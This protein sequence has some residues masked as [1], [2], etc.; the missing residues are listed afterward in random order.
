[1]NPSELDTART[2]ALRG[3]AVAY[4]GQDSFGRYLFGVGFFPDKPVAW[5]TEVGVRELVRPLEVSD[6]HT[7]WPWP[8]AG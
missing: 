4:M 5:L 8:E 6:T 7:Y 1:M 3:Y 2:Y